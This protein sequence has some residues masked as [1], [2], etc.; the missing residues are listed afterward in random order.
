MIRIHNFPRGARGLRVMWLCEEMALAYEVRAV[1]FPPSAAYLAL[2]SLGSVPFLEDD[3]GVAIHESVAML[4]YLAQR[5]GPTPLLPAEDPALL[6]HVLQTAV[7]GEATIASGIN[8]LLVA[9]FT[10]P[11]SEKRNWSVRSQEERI[12]A[13]VRYAA[14]QLGERAFFAGERLTL[15]DISMSPALTLW[16]GVCAQT[17]P[18]NLDAFQERV[19][20]R[21]AYQRARLRCDGT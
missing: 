1:S 4:I 10:A 3:G 21:P 19:K 20:A 5:Y 14:G 9:R 18:A 8:P 6:A 13:A 12:G 7:F 16:H 11:D 17:L 15:A 2:H